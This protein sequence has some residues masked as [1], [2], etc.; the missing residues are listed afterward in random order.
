MTL[1]IPLKPWEVRGILDGWLTQLVRP[2]DLT[3]KGQYELH[4]DEEVYVKLYSTKKKQRWVWWDG[5]ASEEGYYEIDCPFGKPGDVLWCKEPYYMWMSLCYS[6]EK[7]SIEEGIRHYY[8]ACPGPPFHPFSEMPPLIPAEE[9]TE[10]QSRLSILNVETKVERLHELGES[11]F[12]KM[13]HGNPITRDL[14]QP[15]AQSQWDTEYPETPWESNPWVWVA[16]IRKVE[17]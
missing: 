8:R 4:G 17:I 10:K 14:K 9:M 13:G 3:S 12:C 2:V 16:T 6:E 7:S 5:D 15:R 11:D 1:S